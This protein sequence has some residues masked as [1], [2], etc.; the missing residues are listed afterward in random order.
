[1]SSEVLNTDRACIG[2][3]SDSTPLNASFNKA[4][5]FSL[6][7][8]SNS[9]RVFTQF[10]TQGFFYVSVRNNNISTLSQL[11]LRLVKSRP[12]LFENMVCL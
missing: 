6:I 12:V 10:L 4:I 1:M 7:M 11:C 8:D 5:Y 9:N 3:K 2:K